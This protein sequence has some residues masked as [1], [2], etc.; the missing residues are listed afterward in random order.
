MRGPFLARARGN[1]GIRRPT[2]AVGGSALRLPAGRR[3]AGA[4]RHR[5]LDTNAEDRASFA[6]AVVKPSVGE[7][8]PVREG[9]G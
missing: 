9:V 2:F 8:T 7:T 6:R 3:R 5:L 1:G 4:V